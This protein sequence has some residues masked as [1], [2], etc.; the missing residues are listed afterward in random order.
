MP[1]I[2]PDRLV[3][4]YNAEDGLFNAVNDWA[5]KIFSPSTYECYLCRYTFGLMGMMAPWKTF[6]EQQP[7]PTDFF[8]RTEFKHTH[9]QLATLPLPLILAE[10]EGVIEVLLTADEIKGTGGLT[11]LIELVQTKLKHW[12]PAGG[13]SDLPPPPN[14]SAPVSPLGALRRWAA[15][16]VSRKASPPS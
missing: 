6:I 10:K 13:A 11:G 16:R 4:V 1:L 8:H 12:K 2:Q 14:A 5:H 3:M 9:P 7:F 15:A